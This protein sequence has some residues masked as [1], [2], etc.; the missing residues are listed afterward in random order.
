MGAKGSPDKGKAPESLEGLPESV[1]RLADAVNRDTNSKDREA[2]AAGKRQAQINSLQ[3]QFNASLQE[4]ASITAALKVSQDDALAQSERRS[5]REAERIKRAE[6]AQKRSD[7]IEAL[8]SKQEASRSQVGASLLGALFGRG[9]GNFVS[10][11][12]N[13]QEKTR[14]DIAELSQAIYEDKVATAEDTKAE[15]IENA[16][17]EREEAA[18][19]AASAYKDALTRQTESLGGAVQAARASDAVLSATEAAGAAKDAAKAARDKIEAEGTARLAEAQRPTPAE[20]KAAPGIGAE[21]TGKAAPII[22]NVEG[23]DALAEAQ[24]E[25]IRAEVAGRNLAADAAVSEA[26]DKF[27]SAIKAEGAA[28]ARYAGANLQG[29]TAIA[30]IKAAGV[31]AEGAI[32]EAEASEKETRTQAEDT[33]RLA[34]NLAFAGKASGDIV[35]K[36]EQQAMGMSNLVSGA[37]A[38]P[39]VAVIGKVMDKFQNLF[40]VIE[41]AGNALI[42]MG[43]A[44]PATLFT[45]GG[46]LLAGITYGLSEIRDAIW[47]P[48]VRKRYDISNAEVLRATEKA[49][50]V[51]KSRADLFAE[52]QEANIEAYRKG[53]RPEGVAGTSAP[54]L[55]LATRGPVKANARPE[56]TV[57]ETASTTSGAVHAAPTA[58]EVRNARPAAQSQPLPERPLGVVPVGPSNGSIDN[59]RH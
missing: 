25:R 56:F 52:A 55:S 15:V 46:Q 11:A 58:E 57:M 45:A 28:P 24:L 33:S 21:G 48:D 29:E 26:S 1:R 36:A 27:A 4:L 38:P 6:E 39:A 14:A 5:R 32:K 18:A 17:I 7:R 20:T 42:E 30:E 13:A 12:L 50:G 8:R 35:P 16:E 23:N 43:T 49:T 10:N 31:K 2:D 51:A 47:T 9:I 3:G 34:K 59:W 19:N 22:V 53:N 40:P 54:G 37:I 41:Q 44:I